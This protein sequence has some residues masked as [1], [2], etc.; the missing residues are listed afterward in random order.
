MSAKTKQ[1][2]RPHEYRVDCRTC[3]QTTVVHT[4]LKR[5]IK[6]CP[7]CGAK[8]PFMA[9]AFLRTNTEDPVMR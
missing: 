7:R 6:R 5:Q 9:V 1:Y 8:R 4:R 3:H 2:A